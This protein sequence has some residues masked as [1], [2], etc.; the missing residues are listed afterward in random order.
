MKFKTEQE[1]N[2]I[3][4]KMIQLTVYLQLSS[5]LMND[6]S[7]EP[8]IWKNRLKQKGKDF[9]TALTEY[10]SHMLKMYSN[11]GSRLLV[12]NQGELEDADDIQKDFWKIVN[13][14]QDK[15]RQF[16]NEEVL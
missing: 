5:E 1:E 6:L 14:L 9:N 12:N 11:T 10:L 3:L 13:K 7:D 2:E 4:D 8:L 16:L 15:N